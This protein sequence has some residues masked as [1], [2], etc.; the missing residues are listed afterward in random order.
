MTAVAIWYHNTEAGP[1]ILI[2]WLNFSC[3]T[4]KHPLSTLHRFNRTE[5]WMKRAPAS[6]LSASTRTLVAQ[7]WHNCYAYHV[8][9]LSVYYTGLCN[10]TCMKLLLYFMWGFILQ[11]C[12][13]QKCNWYCTRGIQYHTTNI[14]SNNMLLSDINISYFQIKGEIKANGCAIMPS[15]SETVM[16]DNH[17]NPFLII[18]RSGSHNYAIVS[19][20]Y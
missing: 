6:V 2:A 4:L 7:R 19:H 17:L 12:I 20:I 15:S 3:M 18:T 5:Q 9:T 16:T 1:Q 8:F 11:D 14:N 13:M 10:K